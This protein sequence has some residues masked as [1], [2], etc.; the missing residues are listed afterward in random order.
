[1]VHGFGAA[2]TTLLMDGMIVNT[3]GS[4][5]A[6]QNYLTTAGNQEMVYQTGGG[7]G[8]S[9]T[10]GLNINMVPREGGNRFALTSSL[11]VERWQSKKDRIWFFV[12]GRLSKENKPVANTTNS[13]LFTT[14]P[15]TLATLTDPVASSASLAACRAET[16]AAVL[17]GRDSACPVGYSPEIINS[18][19]GRMTVQVAPKTKVQAA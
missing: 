9:L 18:A 11:G 15:M 7:G 5:G 1:S 2:G 13:E 4:D 16:A 10:G 14:N 6:I 8:E 17:A 19:L 12:V 3:L